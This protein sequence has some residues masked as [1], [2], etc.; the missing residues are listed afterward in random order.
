MLFVLHWCHSAFVSLPYACFFRTSQLN[1]WLTSTN[2]ARFSTQMQQQSALHFEQQHNSH[3]RKLEDLYIYPS[4]SNNNQAYVDAPPLKRTITNDTYAQQQQ[5]QDKDVVYSAALP[6]QK[7]AP[8]VA[9][10]P[11]HLINYPAKRKIRIDYYKE[12]AGFAAEDMQ[13]MTIIA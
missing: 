11:P 4:H 9:P 3:K 12:L 8:S 6:T 1:H 5:Q 13:R 2:S 10:P 7:G